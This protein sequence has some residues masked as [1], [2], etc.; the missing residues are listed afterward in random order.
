[1][2]NDSSA[3]RAAL[4]GTR[5]RRPLNA[6]PAPAAPHAPHE[7]PVA[8]HERPVAMH[9]RPVAMHERPAAT[10]RSRRD[11]PGRSDL[12][13]TC[14]AW[15]PVRRTGAWGSSKGALMHGKRNSTW[16]FCP[17][18]FPGS[19]LRRPSPGAPSL[20]QQGRLRE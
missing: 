19:D 4:R 20:P 2:G 11:P 6:A 12:P 18:V 13:R 16:K 15:L 7:R 17:V 8:M 1:M 3:A 5:A 10:D 9:E 14:A